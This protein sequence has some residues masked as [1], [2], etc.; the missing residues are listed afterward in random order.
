MKTM[1]PMH[2]NNPTPR[3]R[4]ER[5]FWPARCS[6]PARQCPG[7]A[8]VVFKQAQEHL[9]GLACRASKRRAEGKQQE[10]GPKTQATQRKARQSAGVFSVQMCLNARS[11]KN[12]N[13][14]DEQAVT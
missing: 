2:S 3:P 7:K 1:N 10:L 11:K 14:R 5:R 9:D 4:P 13:M 8:P 12:K 6:S